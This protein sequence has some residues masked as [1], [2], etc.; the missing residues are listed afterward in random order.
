MNPASPDT[1]NPAS[2][3]RPP[4]HS[5]PPKGTTRE[6]RAPG[7]LLALTLLFLAFVFIPRVRENPRLV[8]AFLATGTALL[9]WTVVLWASA[10][11]RN[12]WFR[13]EFAPPVK[14]HYIQAC[15]HM[16]IYAYWGWYWRKVYDEIPLIVAQILFLYIFDALLSWSRGRGWRLGFGALPIIFSTNLFIWFKDDWYT[17]QFVMVAA[18][19]LG[20]EFI[21]WERDGK[22]THIF[23]PSAFALGL[24]SIILIATE[25]T[26]YTWG[27]EV[28]STLAFPPHIYLWI[29][30]VGLIVQYFFSVTLMTLSATASLCLLNLIYTGITGTYHFVDSNIPIAVFL[31]LH[32]LV[33]DPSTSPRTNAG[34]VL[35]GALYG[36]GNFVLYEIFENRGI[37]EFYD[38][39]LPVLA[40]NLCVPLIDRWA[41]S[42]VVGRFTRWESQ[43]QPRKL[44]LV[45]MACWAALFL[46]M[47]ATGYV[48]APHKG[49]SIAF[50]KKAYAEGK[51]NAGK[52]LLKVVGSQADQGSGV[53]SNELGV[54]YMEGKI[55]PKNRAAAAH[56]F[57]AACQAGNADG[58]ANLAT[59]FLFLREARS[60]KDVARALNRL[61]RECGKGTDGRSCYL[62]GF[63]HETGRGRPVDAER[64]RELYDEGCR[65]GDLDACKSFARIRCS[66][67]GAAGELEGARRVLE[68]ACETGDPESC[69]Y[70]AY[71]WL[72]GNGVER[73][74]QR[75]RALLEKAC[76]LGSDQACDALKQ[77]DLPPCS[78]LRSSERPP[79]WWTPSVSQQ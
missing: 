40:L 72:G 52:K 53:A 20:K 36:L 25:T 6:Q 79:M 21:K 55:A 18:A 61:E 70:L 16:S 17:L 48:D 27:I 7:V 66:G 35:F 34:R 44:N 69:M 77:A 71:F 42:G 26:H 2:N 30:L 4:Q 3:P 58:C 78:V 65:R 43:F 11:R 74:E 62:V 59:Q 76:Q 57:A 10:E 23:N 37:P 60:D 51:H 5:S 9:V 54:I 33:T 41:R 32:L 75:A 63:A 45:H 12:R 14:S 24:V 39:L 29:F 13:I 50:W 1:T 15:V 8:W 67:N 68:T 38:K 49:T 46:T 28:A 47:L 31:G 64:A 73:D 22:R 19:A 56:Y